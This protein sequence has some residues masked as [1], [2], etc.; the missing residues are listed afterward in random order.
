MKIGLIIIVAALVTACISGVFG[1]AG[2]LIFMGVIATFLGVAEAM[3]VHGAVQ[4]VSN[5]YRAFLLKEGVRWDIL[6][7]QLLGALPAISLMLLASI[8]LNK[9]RE[10]GYKVMPRN[11][12]M[13]PFA[14]QW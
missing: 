3:V 7:W 14:A 12:P 5:G 1:M 13:R 10:A 4:S 2:G 6:G 11:R 8:T 9:A